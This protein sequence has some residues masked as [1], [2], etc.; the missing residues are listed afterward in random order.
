MTQQCISWSVLSVLVSRVF[1]FFLKHILKHIVSGLIFYNR[2][3]SVAL[4]QLFISYRVTKSQNSWNWKA[5]PEIIWSNPL[6]LKAGSRKAGCSRSCLVGFWKSPRME[7][8]QPFW[9]TCSTVWS[10]LQY[11]SIFSYLNLISHFS[12]AF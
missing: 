7:K 1:L 2:N 12:V 5:P 9:A 6:L 8:P 11:K 3:K 10:P 4:H